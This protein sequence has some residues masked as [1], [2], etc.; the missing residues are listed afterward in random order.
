MSLEGI[1][2][3]LGG[4]STGAFGWTYFATPFMGFLGDRPWQTT[5]WTYEVPSSA[6][7]TDEADL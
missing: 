5:F 1:T 6:T 4:P 3:I 7:W 2:P